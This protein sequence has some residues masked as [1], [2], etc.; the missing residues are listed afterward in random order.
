MPRKASL[1]LL[2]RTHLGRLPC[3]QGPQ[4]YIVPIYFVYD[5]HYIY[6]FS[7]VGQK[8]EWMRANPLVC[9]EADDVANSTQWQ[10]VIVIGRYEELPDTSEW[11][12]A[13]AFAYKLLHQKA[14]WWEPGYAKTIIKGA[15][16]P[17]IPVF[18][19]IF[20]DQISGH[21]ASPVPGRAV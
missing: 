9:V 6:S 2:A 21:C 14:M 11:H 16:R 15:G 18:Y 10:S 19:R 7:T 8:I 17:L 4:P 20:I 12:D 3:T 13:H 1:Y 5:A